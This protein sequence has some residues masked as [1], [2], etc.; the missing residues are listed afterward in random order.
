MTAAD[1]AALA[2]SVPGVH[3][4]LAVDLYDPAAPAVPAERTA[5]VFP[6]DET[7]HPVSAPVKAQL[8]AVLEAAREVNFVI[9]VENPTYT[10]VEIVY[11]VVAD[12]SADPAIVKVEIDTAL[13]TLLTTWGS[14]A[15]DDQAWTENTQFRLLDVVRVIGRVT[16]VAYVN[17]L[18]ING[19]PND[20]VLDGPAALPS[21]LDDP[22]TPSTI[23]G[24]VA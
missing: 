15:D 7:S 22:A 13:A 6:V 19:T 24:T 2:R 14:T 4:A 16:G 21:P 20:Y 23:T 5:T 10:A 1:L 18:T 3:R 9:H 8:Q 12:T 17:S 11:D